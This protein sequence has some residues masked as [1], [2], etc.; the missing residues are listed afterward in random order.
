MR[1]MA[2]DELAAAVMF[3]EVVGNGE[4]ITGVL[5]SVVWKGQRT[6]VE[7]LPASV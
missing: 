3:S 2:G 7:P 5:F 4:A 1:S 6:E